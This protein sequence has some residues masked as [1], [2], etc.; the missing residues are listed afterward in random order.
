MLLKIGLNVIVKIQL[1]SALA[2]FR[3]INQDFCKQKVLFTDS[4]GRLL[5]AQ[6]AAP[7][8]KRPPPT[9]SGRFALPGLVF[10]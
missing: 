3:W 10:P 1:N 9:G 5:L 4:T 7:I 2:F 6:V 8:Q